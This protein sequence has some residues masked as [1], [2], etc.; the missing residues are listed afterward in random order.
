[1]SE[2]TAQKAPEEP[3]RDVKDA[4]DLFDINRDGFIDAEE[5]KIA[6]NSLGFEFNQQ[7]VERIISEVDPSHKGA[8][9]LEHF[10]DLIQSKMAEREQIDQIQTAFDMLDFDKTGKISFKNLKQIAKDLGENLTDQEIR[11]MLGEADT[12]NDGEISFE[13][14]VGLVR[15]ASFS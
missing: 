2:Q 4:F 5:L 15:T 11:E 7:E 6:F 12:N 8:I 1:M 14:F 10:S 9:D 13:E 3:T